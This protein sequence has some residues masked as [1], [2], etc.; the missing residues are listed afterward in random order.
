MINLWRLGFERFSQILIQWT[1]LVAICWPR[2]I[3]KPRLCPGNVCLFPGILWF[4]PRNLWYCLTEIFDSVS[5]KSLILSHRNFWQV[6]CIPRF[7]LWFFFCEIIGT[8]RINMLLAKLFK[9]HLF[10]NPGSQG[11]HP[12]T[13]PLASSTTYATFRG[14]TMT[15]KNSVIYIA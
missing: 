11:I 12:K 6:L 7:P 9:I 2:S 5:Q 1:F 14:K 4:C 13:C 15:A 8:K 10:C 3:G